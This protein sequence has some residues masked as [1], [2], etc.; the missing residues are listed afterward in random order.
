MNNPFSFGY[1]K[2][3]R[4][5]NRFLSVLISAGGISI[6]VYALA[7]L[8][9][10]LV[11]AWFGV[12][13]EMDVYVMAYTLATV[14]VFSFA[15]IFDTVAVPH[16]VQQHEQEGAEAARALTR[17]LVRA[18]L[19]L[20]VAASVLLLVGT[21]LFAPI[22]VTGF[23]FEERAGLVRLMWG[24][25]P[26]TLFCLP[27]YA[28]AAWYKAQWR[29]GQVFAADI[30]VVLVSIAALALWHESI[31]SLPYAYGIGYAAGLIQ[32]AVGAHLW[33]APKSAR[34]L[35]AVLR[36]IGELYAANQ[37]GALASLVDRHVQSYVPIGGVGAVNYA[38]QI[39]NAL[40][41]LLA[42]R[43]VFVVPLAQKDD[44]DIR[45]ERLICGLVLI[46][47]PISGFVICFAPEIVKVLLEHGR[48]DHAAT[49]LT[50]SVLQINAISLS[51]GAVSTPMFRMFQVVDRI[52]LTHVK[53]LT[54]AAS[55]ALFGYL[56]VGILNLG[57]RGV[58]YMQVSSAIVGFALLACLVAFCGIRV[59][60]WRV[61]RYFFLACAGAGVA[62]AAG[63]LAASPFENVWARLAGG[64]GAFG[65]FVGACYFFARSRLYAI[66]FGT[67]I[68]KNPFT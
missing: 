57:V 39:V 55:L 68:K 60:W 17:K 12:S 67:Q 6:I 58:A 50:S 13:R 3:V 54:S 7:F 62:Y 59:H 8:R 48:F 33:R 32:L 15:N 47:V 38:A 5:T 29:F 20:G 36:N 43:E 63:K 42:F 9:Q 61:L 23:S 40:S 41:G 25:V 44:R 22:I 18:S 30:L 37:T 56:F 35:R 14:V 28:H 53:Y 2:T 19:W 66:A 45:L 16:L 11:A 31:D 64:G 4:S 26:W 65:L 52:H 21:W 46:S 1:T 24:F 49:S 34:P 10:V 51:I 27:Y